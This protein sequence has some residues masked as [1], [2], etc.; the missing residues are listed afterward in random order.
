[1]LSLVLLCLHCFVGVCSLLSL[2]VV[3]LLLLSVFDLFSRQ[4][5]VV[6]VEIT[7]SP[8]HQTIVH[9]FIERLILKVITQLCVIV[10]FCCYCMC[11]VMLYY[12]S[13]V[14][15]SIIVCIK[16]RVAVVCY[17]I[18]YNVTRKLN[19]QSLTRSNR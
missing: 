16:K 4:L 1:M 18:A 15:L 13:T 9:S 3:L 10:W 14:V 6:Q 17:L 2:S 8:G 11:C 7:S 12:L 19:Q 5:D